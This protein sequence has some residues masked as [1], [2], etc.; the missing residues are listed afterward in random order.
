MPDRD[1]DRGIVVGVYRKT[2]PDTAEARL[3]GPVAQVHVST[4]ATGLRC[5]GC[6]RLGDRTRFVVQLAFQGSQPDAEEG[7]V[8]TGL[9]LDIPAGILNSALGTVSH[10]LDIKVFQYHVVDRIRS[11]VGHCAGRRVAGSRPFAV[12]FP[13]LVSGPPSAVA[14]L[15]LTG[16]LAL[17]PLDPGILASVRSVSDISYTVP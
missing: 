10:V 8:E 6:R 17:I 2:A 11:S 7:A 9:R 13:Q 16:K 1:V 14:A 12:H 5:V 3:R 4:A 15:L